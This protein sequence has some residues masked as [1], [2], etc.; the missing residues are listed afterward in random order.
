MEQFTKGDWRVSCD[1]LDV[2]IIKCDGIMVARAHSGVNVPYTEKVKA[3]ANLISSGP[4]MYAVLKMIQIE[5]G[6]SVARHKQ[7]DKV[8]A[9]ARGES[10]GK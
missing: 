4:D 7:V 2:G 1:P 8:L 10:C 3:N 6:L 5:G 9:K